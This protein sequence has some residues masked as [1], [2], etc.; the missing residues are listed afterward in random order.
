MANVTVNIQGNAG[1]SSGGNAGGNATSSPASGVNYSPNSVQPPDPRLIEEVRRSVIQQGGVFIPGSNNNTYKP[2]IQQAEQIQREQ[3]NSEI[4]NK[5]NARRADSQTRMTEEYGRIDRNIDEGKNKA[6]SGITDINEKSKIET[7][8]ESKR[9][10]EITKA[11]SKFD[12]ENEKIDKE[13]N[14]ERQ[15]SNED[16]TRVIK[17]L[18]DEIKKNGGNLNP[19]SFLSQLRQ[20]RQKAVIDRDTAEDEKTANEAAARVRAIDSKI[21]DVVNGKKEEPKIDYGLRTIQT[22]M[23]FDQIVRG[24]VNKDLGSMIMGGGQA[25]TSM[26]GMSDKAA[27]RSL[28]FLKPLATVGTLFT[29]EAQKSDQMAGLAA[30]IRGDASIE[31]TRASMYEKMWDY[32]PN[33]SG[34]ASIYNMGLSVPE[35]AQSSERR[36]KQRGVAQEG[37]T[38]SYFQEALERVFSLSNGSLGEAGRFDRYGV[39]ATDAI[40]NLVS[41]LS[42]IQNSGI[43]QGNFVRTQEYLGMQQELMSQYMRFQDK[44]SYGAAN[45]DIEAFASLKNYTVDG[46]T[47]GDIKSVQNQ[48]INPQNDRMKAVL[49]GVVEDLVPEYKKDGKTIGYSA[50]RTDIIDQILHDPEYQGI[51]QRGLMQKLTSMYGGADTPMGYW[52]MQ[53]QLPGIESPQ[54]RRSIWEGI[55]TGEAGEKLATGQSFQGSNRDEYAMQANNYNTDIT[56]LLVTLSDSFYSGASS[57]E[58]ILIDL[59]KVISGQQSIFEYLKGKIF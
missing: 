48:L 8:W 20:E 29:Q 23:G 19:N 40:S 22:M 39:N 5:Y 44:P 21:N 30:L 33:G 2:I 55:T 52:M 3:I 34:Y 12:I 18:T 13:E 26:L 24:I 27:A 56:Q 54:R 47:T 45:R 32:S 37:V 43:S 4:S 14:Q 9:D 49:Y 28:A 58:N 31:D 15:K 42:R 53:S 11:G 17:D 57:L 59:K 16:L 51:V 1:S 46:R 10:S 50:G 41:R 36:I 7:F 6:L 35:F 38:E 25:M